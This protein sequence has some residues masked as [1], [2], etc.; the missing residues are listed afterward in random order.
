MKFKCL[1]IDDEPLAINVIKTHLSHFNAFE[2]VYTFESAIDAFNYLSTNPVQLLF[3]DINLP[4]LSG[5]DFIKNLDQPP[6]VIV[7]TAYREYA[8]ESFELDVLDYLVKPVAFPRFM[9]AIDKATSHLQ[10]L[11]KPLAG[12]VQQPEPEDYIF[13]RADKKNIKVQHADILYIESLKDYIRIKTI[14]EDLI[15]HQNLSQFTSQLPAEK[16][17][18]IHRSFTVSCEKISSISGTKLYVGPKALPIGR[19][20]QKEVKNSILNKAG[21]N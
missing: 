16:F 13:V 3:L 10:Q 12:A 14:Y 17:L 5:I 21:A 8:V 7:T 18:R 2:V 19:I 11:D 4:G 15:V 20:F 6:A 9:K 1:I